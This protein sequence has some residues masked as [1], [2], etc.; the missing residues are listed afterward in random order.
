MAI[1]SFLIPSIG[2]AILPPSSQSVAAAEIVNSKRAPFYSKAGRFSINFPSEPT[3]SQENNEVNG[4]PV[5]SFIAVNDEKL[6]QVFYG[7]IPGLKSF[8]RKNVRELLGESVSSYCTELQAK[9]ID[10]KNIQLGNNVGKE[11][12]CQ[13]SD[14]IGIGRAYAAGD[15]IYVIVSIGNSSRATSSFFNSFRLR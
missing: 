6:Y 8:P 15:R 11:F 5:Y 7:D 9:L 1:A 4:K 2:L 13:L 14:Q 10:T 12:R 3:P